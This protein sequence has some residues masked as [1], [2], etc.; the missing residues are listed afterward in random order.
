MGEDC[1]IILDFSGSMHEEGKQA[2]GDYLV[3]AMIGFIRDCF[4]GL[5]C[6]A[7]KWSREVTRYD[8]KSD[9]ADARPDA[10]ALA[11]FAFQHRE[12]PMILVSDGN[13]PEH[14][15]RSLGVLSSIKGVRAVMVGADANRA[16]LQKVVGEGR[17]FDSV[18]AIECVRQLLSQR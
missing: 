1:L 14:A 5:C 17:V 9:A 13:F 8:A 11:Q 16:R 10:E 18:D 12:T 7:Y 4:P 2:A 3:R 15:C 6:G